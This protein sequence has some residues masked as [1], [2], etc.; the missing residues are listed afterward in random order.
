MRVLFYPA[1]F[2]LLV[3]AVAGLA[4]ATALRQTVPLAVSPVRAQTA[5]VPTHPGR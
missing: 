4:F 3:V 1:L 5:P 2:V